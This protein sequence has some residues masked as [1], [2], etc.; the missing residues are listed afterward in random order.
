MLAVEVIPDPLRADFELILFEPPTAPDAQRYEPRASKTP[1]PALPK[2]EPQQPLVEKR[3]EFHPAEPEIEIPAARPARSEFALVADTARSRLAPS[4]DAPQVG[5][6]AGA[7]SGG[8]RAG[9]WP[10]PQC[11][12]Q[13]LSPPAG[14]DE[15]VAPGVGR[16]TGAPAGRER[17]A[18]G[19]GVPGLA[20]SR[21]GPATFFD[22]TVPGSSG[23]GQGRPGGR[24]GVAGPG[25]A[26]RWAA[27]AKPGAPA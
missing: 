25:S 26:S 10:S 15:P 20:L 7:T 6:G 12:G 22:I 11:A 14:L 3:I 23:R 21:P 9:R 2:V 17:L 5:L 4:L 8:P 27:P 24:P 19:D 13:A 1:R 18:A 16:P